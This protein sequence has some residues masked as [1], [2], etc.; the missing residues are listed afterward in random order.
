MSEPI[1]SVS[2]LRGTIPDQLTPLVA[3]RYIAALAS[4]LP[5]GKSRLGSRWSFERTHVSRRRSVATLAAHGFDVIDLDAASTPTVGIQVREQKPWP[6]FRSR[7]VTIQKNITDSN[8]LAA[9][10]AFSPSRLVKKCSQ[11]IELVNANGL[12]SMRSGTSKRLDDPHTAHMNLVLKT[13]EPSQV[14]GR[15]F[16]V[17]LDSNH[18]AGSLLGRMLLESLGCELTLLGDTPDGQ[19]EHK[20]EPLAENLARCLR[21]GASGGFDVGFCQD[22]DAD[23]LAIIDERGQYI[24]EE[25][26]LALCLLQALP[27]G[28]GTM[29][30]NCASSSLSQHIAAQYESKLLTI[31]GRRSQRR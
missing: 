14:R 22:P 21:R 24:G 18:G 26:T 8:C 7:Q 25:M 27:S 4:T 31:G 17:L 28:R 13:I 30:T 23:R 1:I 2:G 19:F 9:M 10:V 3:T 29:V 12:A 6:V 20:P 15:K 5:L 11:V 16:K